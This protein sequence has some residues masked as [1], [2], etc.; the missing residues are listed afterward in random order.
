MFLVSLSGSGKLAGEEV[1]EDYLGAGER[2]VAQ[3]LMGGERGDLGA[4]VS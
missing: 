3:L 1:A 4:H 2:V